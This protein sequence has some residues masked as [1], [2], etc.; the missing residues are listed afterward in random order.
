MK[1]KLV[2]ARTGI[3]WVREGM[4]I[5]WRMPLAFAGLLVMFLAAATALSL[6]PLAGNLLTLTLLPAFTVGLMAAT[7]QAIEGRLPLPPVLL[8]AFRRS[9]RQTRATL[10]LG[11]LCA[12]ALLLIEIIASPIDGGQLAEL[13]AQHGENIAAETMMADPALQQAARAWMR[14]QAVIVVLSVPVTVLLWHAPALVYWHDMPIGKS[15]FFSAVAVLRNA[16]AYLVYVLGWMAVSGIAWTGLIVLTGL[17][18]GTGLAIAGLLPLSV[19]VMSMVYAS[20]WF[21][22]RDSFGADDPPADAPTFVTHDA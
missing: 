1:L 2:P 14:E 9:P 22:F 10:A 8:S 18:G 21:T 12:G 17:A 16:P 7:R 3:R 15:L 4:R 20:L 6:I 13:I 11:A 19:L 5:F